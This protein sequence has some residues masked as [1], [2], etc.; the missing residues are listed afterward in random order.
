M[1][2]HVHGT[3]GSD[4]AFQDD[5]DGPAD[6]RGR[7]FGEAGIGALRITLLFGSAAVALALILTPIVATQTERMA[8]ARSPGIDMM[9]TGSIG[10]GVAAGIG[11]RSPGA[12]VV[13]RSVLQPTANSV[14]IIRSNGMRTGDC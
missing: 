8:S 14:C 4:M 12:Y 9:A 2:N 13:R 5:W 11:Q 6:R 3:T 7:G 1:F 10:G